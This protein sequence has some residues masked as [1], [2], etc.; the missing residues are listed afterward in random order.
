MTKTK[1]S[2]AEAANGEVVWSGNE[3]LRPYLVPI[4]ELQEDPDNANT[5]P[6]RSIDDIAGSYHR[7][8]QQKPI[9]CDTSGLVKDGNG[10]LVAASG[11]GWTHLAVL[12]SD[13][14]GPELTAYALAVNR[15]PHA[16]EWDYDQL[17]RQLREL[18]EAGVETG[19]LGW[20]P[21]ELEELLSGL[22]AARETTNG[23]SQPSDGDTGRGVPG[24]DTGV[25]GNKGNGL[26]LIA[27]VVRDEPKTEV[28]IGDVFRLG[29]HVLLCCDV[30]KDW[31]VWS[32]YLEGDALFLPYPSPFLPLATAKNTFV[33][34]QPDTYLCA[35]T[36]DLYDA[37]NPGQGAERCA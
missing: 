22:H 17:T 19:D 37:A 1:K 24:S 20:S 35:V 14:Q 8:G 6:D 25:T 3:A 29:R 18:D 21:N 33:L 34:V 4:R 36:C 13:L 11:L 12:K 7:F 26:A 30:L 15:T 32:K 16:A 28:V 2:K 10:Q 31:P 9:V 23:D 5:H 27:D